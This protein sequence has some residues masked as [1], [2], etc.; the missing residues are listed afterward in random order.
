MNSFF[1]RELKTL[2]SSIDK[3][4]KYS[5]RLGVVGGVLTGINLRYKYFTDGITKKDAFDGIVTG[6][7]I[8][9]SVS[10]PVGIAA[11]GIYGLLDA[12][13]VLDGIKESFGAN[14]DVILK[15]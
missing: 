4:G 14:D 8:F 5:K 2:N 3:L 9:V 10:N 7:L 1:R 15:Y 6:A 13:G 12:T 11:L